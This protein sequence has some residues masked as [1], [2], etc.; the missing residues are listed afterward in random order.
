MF[1]KSSLKT[2][3]FFISIIRSNKIKISVCESCGDA[4]DY[5]GYPTCPECIRDGDTTKIDKE[6]P[7]LLQKAKDAI[8]S[9][10]T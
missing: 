4:F 5:T 10:T 9:T 3:A 1:H 8:Q 2:W 7:K 6:I